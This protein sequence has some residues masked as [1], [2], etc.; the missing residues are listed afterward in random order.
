[1]DNYEKVYT[2]DPRYFQ[3]NLTN[4]I[5]NEE[6]DDVLI[7]N[8]SQFVGHELWQTGFENIIYN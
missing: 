7:L 5:S 8:S 3:G 2:V 1:M 4:F 6:I